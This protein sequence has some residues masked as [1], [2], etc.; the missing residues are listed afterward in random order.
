MV[1]IL[2]F[3]LLPQRKLGFESLVGEGNLENLN[4]LKRYILGII[5]F[6]FFGFTILLGDKIAPNPYG[7]IARAEMM[8]SEERFSE[9][10]SELN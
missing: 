1:L 8:I 5:W 2:G 3:A 7:H 9:A 6:V 10:E 4:L